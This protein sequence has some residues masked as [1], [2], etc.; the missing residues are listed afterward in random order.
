MKYFIIFFLFFGSSVFAQVILTPNAVQDSIFNQLNLFPQEKIHLHTDRTMYVPGEKI[1]FKAYIVDAFSHK[2]PTLSQYVYIELINSSDS[3]VHRVMICPDDFGLFHGYIFLSEEIPKE[4]YTLRAYTRYMENLGDDFFFKKNIRIGNINGG[5]SG[6]SENRV[7]GASLALAR[8]D[9]DVAFFPEGGNLVEGVIGRIAFKAL[10]KQSASEIIT[11]KIVDEAGNL[12]VSGIKTVFAGMGS[13]S[14]GPKQEKEYFLIA[15]SLSGQEKRFKLPAAQ[16]TYAVSSF[17][18]DNLHFIQVKHTPGLPVQPLYLLV[19]CKGEVLYF[20]PWNF[21]K[22]YVSFSYNLLPSGV[23]Q[24]L[25]LDAHMNPVSERLIFNKNKDTG[26][27]VFQTDKATYGK[28]EKVIATL[29]EASSL[30]PSLSGRDGVGLFSVAITDDADMSI[31]SLHT[32]ASSLLLSSELRGYIESPGYYLQDHRH[33]VYALDH[34]MMTHGW[35]RYEL[36]GSLKGEYIRPA[37]EYE[38]AKEINGSLKGLFSR[39]VTNGEVLLVSKDQRFQQT[40]TDVDGNFRFTGLHF[41]DSISFFLLAK[42]QKGSENVEIVL[43]PETF[44]TPKHAPSDLLFSG[45]GSNNIELTVGEQFNKPIEGA[46]DFIKKAEKRAQYDEDMKVINLEEVLVT[47]K[48]IERTTE[49]RA[50]FALNAASDRT[51]DREMIKNRMPHATFIDQLFTLIL[52]AQFEKAPTIPGGYILAS[53]MPMAGQPLYYV[54]GLPVDR[55]YVSCINPE[56]VESIDVFQRASAA[57]FGTRGGNGVISITT[58]KGPIFDKD[59]SN[60]TI[61]FVPLGYQQPIEFYSP[62]YDTP[63]SKS[64]AVPDYRTTIF[65]KPDI[66]VHDD[67]HTSF[68]FYTS[69]FPTTYSVVIEGITKE[70]KIIRQVEKIEVQ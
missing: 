67:G 64:F 69:D 39:P 44:P 5:N 22:E 23:I 37:K 41:A 66:I 38:L 8:N 33:A 6:S 50:Q 31:D 9:F 55:E 18:R 51:I 13:F 26:T 52:G 21:R 4:V 58:R 45:A 61:S 12:I 20:A 56:N 59:L 65:W 47:A 53:L 68:E 70:G 40:T 42:D 32:I 3:L 27:I 25:L 60:N 17:Y 29:S 19:H 49:L 35:R 1:W 43:N 30:S 28:R 7:E 36:S 63:A 16:K 62:K 14:F 11:G 54:D 15:T 2:S 10:N 57:M 48:K 46:S 24:I 34:L